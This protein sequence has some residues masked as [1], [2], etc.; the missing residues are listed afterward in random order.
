MLEMYGTFS[1]VLHNKSNY[2]FGEKAI[3]SWH[4]VLF[5]EEVKLMNLTFPEPD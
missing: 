4:T 2:G 5:E 1:L 3:F